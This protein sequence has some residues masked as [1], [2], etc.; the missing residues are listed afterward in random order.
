MPTT[1]RKL[2]RVTST[3]QRRSCTHHIDARGR[4]EICANLRFGV[5]ESYCLGKDACKPCGSGFPFTMTAWSCC[6]AIDGRRVA[7]VHQETVALYSK[8]NK[9]RNLTSRKRPSQRVNTCNRSIHRLSFSL[10]WWPA[11]TVEISGNKRRGSDKRSA[12][13]RGSL[14][15]NAGG[16]EASSHGIP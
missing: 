13:K 15:D 14:S 9:L 6:D 5:R 7:K 8:V 2:H 4:Q 16:M 11:V 10:F 3:H 1:P 12:C